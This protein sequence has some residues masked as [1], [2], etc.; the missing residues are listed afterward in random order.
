MDIKSLREKAHGLMEAG[1][2]TLKTQQEM[3]AIVAERVRPLNEVADLFD[4]FKSDKE[5]DNYGEKVLEDGYLAVDTETSGLDTMKDHVVGVCL[6]TPNEKGVYVPVNHRDAKSLQLLDNQCS[7]SHMRTWFNR[8]IDGGVKFLFH[9]AKFDLA[10]IRTT[11]EVLLPV[12]WDT[13]VASSLL[14]E[15]EVHQLKVL[16]AKYCGKERFLGEELPQSYKALFGDAVFEYLPPE[17][18]YIYGARDSIMT[19]DLFKFQEPFLTEDDPKCIK[20]GLQDVA[21]LFHETEMPLVEALLDMEY[22]GVSLNTD[23]ISELSIKYITKRNEEADKTNRFIDTEVLTR[24]RLKGVS[25]EVLSKLGNPVNLN[26]P[27]QLSILLYD[28]LKLPML[29]KRSTDSPTLEK[30]IKRDD[31][32]SNF[33]ELINNI[34]SYREFEKLINTYVEKLPKSRNLVTGRIHCS[35]NQ[36]GAATG[37]LCIG[38]GSN[39]LVRGLTGVNGKPIEE[40]IEGDLALTHDSVGNLVY[41]RVDAAECTGVKD[42]MR[43]QFVNDVG[44]T[45]VVVLTPDHL[46]ETEDGGWVKAECLSDYDTV[47]GVSFLMEVGS[48]ELEGA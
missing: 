10:M 31:V 11:F 32:P 5:L 19:Y 16:W 6:Y 18:V 28:I 41:R 34:L 47:K 4:W 7:I 2:R 40:V 14:N 29:K 36:N 20:Q 27:L 12:Y 1:V 9:N 33:K 43:V 23:T 26:S 13:Q 48:D 3:E 8:W 38:E 22:S 45:C 35:F 46:V 37:R 24:E 17:L 15:N 42:V 44:E 39:V 30:L 21:K 25:Q